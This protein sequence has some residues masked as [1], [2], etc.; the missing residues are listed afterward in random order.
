VGCKVD[1]EWGME[2][3][4]QQPGLL[5]SFTDEFKINDEQQPST[6]GIPAKALQLG[7]QPAVQGQQRTYYRSG[8]GNL[9]H[10]RRWSRP[11]MANAVRDL[12]RFN[13]NSSEEHMTA[14]HRAM[15]YA[16]ATPE[17]GL[18]LT[19]EGCWDGNPSF[20]FTITGMADASY[21]PSHDTAQS[22][23]GH[24]VFL[25]G[26]PIAEKSKVQ[27]STTLSVTEAELNSGVECVQDMM[28]AMRVLESIGL[29][30]K[31][32]MEI[33]IYNRGSGPV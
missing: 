16:I 7:N 3:L 28:F 9:M 10:L 17:R 32:P 31:K 5:Q 20:E 1:I 23:V 25:Q 15:C 8:V 24:P 22:V 27:H 29:Q 33:T 26:A 12:S 30:V 21:K 14:M 2:T 19:P 13:T 18:T 4:K 6:P 11:E